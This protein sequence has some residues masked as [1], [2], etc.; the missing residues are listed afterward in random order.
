MTKLFMRLFVF[1]A[2]L[3]VVP[4]YSACGDDEEDLTEINHDDPDM[5]GSGSE[6]G[7]KVNLVGRTVI[8]DRTTTSHGYDD[9]L[10]LY[11]TF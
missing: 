9:Y 1:S 4:I 6:T 8:Y 11:V 5:P 7:N 3:S 10:F 2:F